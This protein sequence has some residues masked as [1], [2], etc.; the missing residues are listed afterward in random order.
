MAHAPTQPVQTPFSLGVDPPSAHSSTSGY[1]MPP[2]EI[3]NDSCAYSADARLTI[4]TNLLTHAERAGRRISSEVQRILENECSILLER[5]DHS[6]SPHRFATI[7]KNTAVRLFRQRRY[8]EADRRYRMAS[9]FDPENVTLL[10]N[11]ATCMY[12][13]RR[14]KRCIELCMHCLTAFPQLSSENSQ[15]FFKVLLRIARAH[16]ELGNFADARIAAQAIANT[17]ANL[18]KAF[19]LHFSQKVIDD[20]M[21]PFQRH[22]DSAITKFQ[23][24]HPGVPIPTQRSNRFRLALGISGYVHHDTNFS[25]AVESDEDS[26]DSDD[27]LEDI[28]MSDGESSLNESLSPA[29]RPVTI[30]DLC[31]HMFLGGTASC[32]HEETPNSIIF[33]GESDL[34]PIGDSS[35]VVFSTSPSP[36]TTSRRLFT[37]RPRRNHFNANAIIE[38]DNSHEDDLSEHSSSSDSCQNEN[39]PITSETSISAL[40]SNPDHSQVSNTEQDGQISTEQNRND[41]LLNIFA[42]IPDN[43]LAALI[44][45]KRIEDSVSELPSA[46]EVLGE[47]ACLFSR[48]EIPRES[49]S[50]NKISYES[51]DEEVQANSVLINTRACKDYSHTPRLDLNERYNSCCQLCLKDVFGQIFWTIRKPIFSKLFGAHQMDTSSPRR[52]PRCIKHCG[53]CF[54]QN[55]WNS[56]FSSL[57]RDEAAKFVELCATD[58]RRNDLTFLRCGWWVETG[59]Y[60]SGYEMAWDMSALVHGIAYAV[61]LQNE[62]YWRGD[63]IPLDA[64]VER[65]FLT[66]LEKHTQSQ[67]GIDFLSKIVLQFQE[68]NLLIGCLNKH[69]SDGVTQ[70]FQFSSTSEAVAKGAWNDGRSDNCLSNNYIQWMTRDDN[71]FLNLYNW[72]KLGSVTKEEEIVYKSLFNNAHALLTKLTSRLTRTPSESSEEDPLSDGLSPFAEHDDDGWKSRVVLVLSRKRCRKIELAAWEESGHTFQTIDGLLSRAITVR[73][74]EPRLYLKRARLRWGQKKADDCLFDLSTARGLLREPD[75]PSDASRILDMRKLLL[76]LHVYMLEAE[77]LMELAQETSSSQFPHLQNAREIFE[78]ALL[79]PCIKRKQKMMIHRKLRLIDSKEPRALKITHEDEK[80]GAPTGDPDS[81]LS[82]DANEER[83]TSSLSNLKSTELPSTSR[84]SLARSSIHSNPEADKSSSSSDEDREISLGGNPYSVLS[85]GQQTSHARELGVGSSAS[86]ARLNE[87]EEQETADSEREPSFSTSTPSRGSVS[88]H[89]SLAPLACNVCNIVFG[90]NRIDFDSHMSGKRHRQAVTRARRV[91]NETAKNRGNRHRTRGTVRREDL[92]CEIRSVI[93]SCGGGETVSVILRNLDLTWWRISD[94]SLYITQHFGSLVGFCRGFPRTFRITVNSES[95]SMIFVIDKA[96]RTASSSQTLPSNERRRDSEISNGQREVQHNIQT[97]ARSIS[98]VAT[99][100]VGRQ[101]RASS[102][103]RTSQTEQ[104]A[105]RLN[106]ITANT[107]LQAAI[108]SSNAWESNLNVPNAWANGAPSIVRALRSSGIMSASEISETGGSRSDVELSLPNINS[109]VASYS[110][111]AGPSRGIGFESL[112]GLEGE[113]FDDLECKICMDNEADLR[114][115]PCGHTWCE[116]CILG[117]I[118]R[119]RYDCPYCRCQITAIE[120]LRR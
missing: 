38:D 51:E 106:N 46:S 68:T 67:D 47:G 22:M 102:S 99:R 72:S 103:S 40:A 14:Y 117:N 36:A 100:S 109:G 1:A 79:L 62:L 10:S 107:G 57:D 115:Q 64:D 75:N 54:A 33:F 93:M 49:Q 104:E 86:H 28:D 15:L 32:L 74:R 16:I 13:L 48:N 84:A 94:A 50:A 70:S 60:A 105:P 30:S 5:P 87:N 3:S 8:R 7:L 73:P 11:R 120:E 4:I 19:N 35:P 89:T 113:R 45:D 112:L 95:D 110:P 61:V 69:R 23:Q 116:E 91:E 101:V 80:R 66:S 52:N 78:K 118:A 83:V 96:Q 12:N 108:G 25:E 82:G 39:L 9:L 98:A 56:R 85:E 17:R 29:P 65:K 90:R 63:D 27:S 114:C 2:T 44:V 37:G 41:Q 26:P 34:S 58:S 119:Q 43:S 111:P 97:R 42:N 53:T 6:Y 77:I 88:K 21:L 76:L 31:P 81:N 92:L 18:S 24:R 55:M 71:C 20:L 59:Y